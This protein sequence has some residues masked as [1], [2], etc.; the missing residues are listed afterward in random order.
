[1]TK[2]HFEAIARILNAQ[3]P[4]GDP[5]RDEVAAMTISDIASDLA[6]YFASVNPNFSRQRFLDAVETRV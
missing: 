1:M 5:E 6:D 2:T 4:W 3:T